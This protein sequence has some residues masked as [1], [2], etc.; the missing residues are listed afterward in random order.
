MS[1]IPQLQIIDGG[2]AKEF[3]IAGITLMISPP[4]RAPFSIDARVREEDTYL[5]LD[6]ET[7]IRDPRQDIQGLTE[8]VKNFEPLK[9]GKLFRLGGSPMQLVAIVYDVEQDPLCREEWIDAVLN[10]LLEHCERNQFHAIALP[11]LGLRHGHF[12]PQRFL[13]RLTEA[14]YARP[15]PHLHKIWLSVPRSQLA[16][17]HRWLSLLGH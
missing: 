17:T 4:D 14:L 12:A 13:L 3:H 1:Q 10:E 9:P 5:L 2:L 6:E 8:S 15:H 16:E 11:L 7:F